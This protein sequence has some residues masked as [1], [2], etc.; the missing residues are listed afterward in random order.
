MRKI[1]EGNFGG[2]G[3]ASR[4]SLAMRSAPASSNAD[5]TNTNDQTNKVEGALI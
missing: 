5:Q 4:P 2:G 3:S 1:G